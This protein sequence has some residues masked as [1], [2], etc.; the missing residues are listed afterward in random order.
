MVYVVGVAFDLKGIENLTYFEPPFR[1]N[2]MK[3]QLARLQNNLCTVHKGVIG[4][5]IVKQSIIVNTHGHTA[6]PLVSKDF[7]FLPLP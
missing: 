3:S 4:E 6:L 5:E 1:Y 7:K 2:T